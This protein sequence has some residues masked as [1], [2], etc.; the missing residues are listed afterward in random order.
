MVNAALPE[1]L[2]QLSPAELSELRDAIQ[3]KLDGDVPAA[4][5]AILEQRIAEADAN[6]DDYITLDEWKARRSA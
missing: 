5:R 3:A 6:P 1:Q 2:D 4:Q